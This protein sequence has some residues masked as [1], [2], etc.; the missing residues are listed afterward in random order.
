MFI[1]FIELKSGSKTK[2]L[3]GLQGGWTFRNHKWR[4][5][6]KLHKRLSFNLN[7]FENE[8]WGT[9]CFIMLNGLDAPATNVRET[10]MTFICFCLAWTVNKRIKQ[11]YGIQQVCCRIHCLIFVASSL[12]TFGLSSTKRSRHVIRTEPACDQN[13]CSL[14]PMQMLKR[15]KIFQNYTRTE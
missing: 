6:C 11:I 3:F 9:E 8:W 12:A 1:G 10:Y 7:K 5:K 13:S 2:K 15:F 14:S 4:P